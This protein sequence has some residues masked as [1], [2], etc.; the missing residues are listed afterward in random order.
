VGLGNTRGGGLSEVKAGEE[1]EFK[2][3]GEPQEKKDQ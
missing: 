1:R 2:K 3:E